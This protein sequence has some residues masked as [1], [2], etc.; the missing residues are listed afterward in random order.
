MSRRFERR[1]AIRAR[2]QRLHE[3]A[4]ED[5]ILP[6][7]VEGVSLRMYLPDPDD[8]IPNRI[9]RRASLYADKELQRIASLVGTGRSILDI[10]ANIG[11]HAV[12]FGTLM[13]ARRIVCYEPQPDIVPILERN[14]ALNDIPATVRPV[15]LGEV[16][17]TM[18]MSDTR[19]GNT[20]ATGFAPD[21]TGTVQ[22]V[23]LDDEGHDA[24]DFIKIDVEGAEPAVIA[25]GMELI[26][27]DRPM[28][29][30]EVLTEDVR[31]RIDEMLL[32]LGYGVKNINE[33]NV[34]YTPQG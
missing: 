32:P 3:L 18:A 27:R 22:A 2:L 33:F 8:H 1:Q 21:E 16:T 24:V 29:M 11:N 30:A 7:T 28:I 26:R 14:I 4:P 17:G 15:A 9:V 34:F 5:R 23:R 10:G 6:I 19:E 13:Q 31:R 25:G 20:G 12:Y